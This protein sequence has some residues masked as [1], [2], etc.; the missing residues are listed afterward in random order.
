MHHLLHLLHLDCM[1]TIP[2]CYSHLNLL[3]LCLQ[4]VGVTSLLW[5]HHVRGHSRHPK[6]WGKVIRLHHH[7]GVEWSLL[8]VFRLLLPLGLAQPL[9]G[10]LHLVLKLLKDV[11]IDLV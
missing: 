7:P 5:L 2:V 9:A 1:D 3:E 4:V 10:L 11:L 6:L 8:I